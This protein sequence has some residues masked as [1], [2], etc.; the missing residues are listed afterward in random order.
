METNAQL[1]IKISLL[2]PLTDNTK[3]ARLATPRGVYGRAIIVAQS[4]PTATHAVRHVV[5]NLNANALG[6]VSNGGKSIDAR[7]Q[8][9]RLSTVQ[10]KDADLV[11]V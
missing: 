6:L 9:Y 4:T 7:L 3:H 5:N 8:D 2:Q 10:R 1:T 11:G